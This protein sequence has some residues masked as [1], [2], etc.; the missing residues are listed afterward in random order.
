MS[1]H[2]GPQDRD[3]GAEPRLR[4]L[5]DALEREFL[6]QLDGSPEVR[7]DLFLPRVDAQDCTTVWTADPH[8]LVDG[9]GRIHRPAADGAGAAVRLTA[10]VEGPAGAVQRTF[11]LMLPPLPVADEPF[12]YLMVHFVETQEEGGEQ[13]H[14]SLS[15]GDDPLHW[16]RLN[17]GRPVLWSEHGTRGVRDP[18]I[19]RSPHGDRF[20]IVATDEQV[21]VN[22]WE[23]T[24]TRA[25]RHMEVWSSD[26]LVTWGPQHHVLLMDDRAGMVWAPEAV[27]DPGRG[28]YLLHWTSNLHPE[29]ADRSV[30]QDMKIF[31]AW[32]RDF[33]H[34]STPEV[35]MEAAA[36]PALSGSMLDSTVTFHDGFFYRFVKGVVDGCFDETGSPLGDVFVERSAT[37]DAPMSG[38]E[39]VAAGI[40]YRATGHHPYEGPLVFRTHRG[41]RWF[42]FA[43]HHGDGP[44]GYVPFTTGDIASDDWSRV[45]DDAS[46]IPPRTKHGSVLP[47]TRSEWVRLRDHRW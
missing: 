45:A 8:G 32:T 2:R 43:D 34:V 28:E 46:G 13:V 42:M 24:T 21:R 11:D 16:Y 30:E 22:G 3:A 39:R 31:R 14:F 19:V 20:H 12:G 33:L 7:S 6:G 25:S 15:D 44:P 9:D 5:V 47:L 35:W 41:D 18:Q 29:G 27:H 17:D 38:W 40:T 23:G 4:T 37:L 26:D 36:D 10:R 1:G